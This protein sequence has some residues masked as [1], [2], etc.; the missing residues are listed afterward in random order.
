MRVDG[1]LCCDGC[2]DPAVFPLDE[3]NH[4]LRC[5]AM[6]VAT[7]Q[8]GSEAAIA[9]IVAAVEVAVE[10]YAHPNDILAAVASTLRRSEPAVDDAGTLAWKCDRN[11]EARGIHRRAE[12]GA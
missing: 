11:Y 4:C 2:G 3:D 9:V 10:R 7:D 5:A 1:I 6:L 12:G 8:H